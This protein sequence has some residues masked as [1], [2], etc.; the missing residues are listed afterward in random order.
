M[1][2]VS[3]LSPT[4]NLIHLNQAQ[5]YG[6]VCLA[7][8]KITEKSNMLHFALSYTYAIDHKFLWFIG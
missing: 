8:V 3:I 7:S 6:V 5:F 4:N 2:G 1:W